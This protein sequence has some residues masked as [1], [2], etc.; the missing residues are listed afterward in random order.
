MILTHSYGVAFFSQVR[1]KRQGEF[2][3]R[4]RRYVLRAFLSVIAVGLAGQPAIA[5]I[6]A[7]APQSRQA[8]G[9]LTEQTWVRVGGPLG[10]LG[11]DIRMRPDNPDIMFVTDALA[12]VH[13]STD[14]GKTWFPSNDGIDGRQGL[15][16]DAIPAF[17][18]TIDPNNPDTV[19]AGLQNLGLVYR[20]TDGGKTWKRRL[21][22][23]VDGNGL[24]L[25]G[26]AVEPGNS[27]VVYTA[28]EISGWKWA[29][30]NTW[31]RQFER[32]KGVVYKSTDGGAN[33]RAVWRGDNL[34]RYV[35][36]DPKNVNTLYV[37]TGIFDREAANSDAAKQEPGGVGILKSTD[38]GKTWTQVNTGLRNLYTGS[39]FMN[40]ANPQILL[41]GAG[42]NTY[43]EGG[44]IYLTTDGG[45]HWKY[46][47]GE[48]ITSV[49]FA[50]SDPNIAYAGGD[51][52]FY[53]SQDGGQNWQLFMHRRGWGWG[54]DGVRAG[55]PI[56]FQVDPR[57]PAR[58]FVNNY[59]GGNFLSEDNGRTW[60]SSSTG[61]TGAELT[62]VS[63]HPSNPSIVYVNGRSGP[64]VSTN[65]GLTWRG[66]NLSAP[67]IAEGGRITLDPSNPDH[68]L[69]SSAHWGWTYEIAG[70]NG[71]ML[72]RT[73]LYD[74]LDRLPYPDVNQK[75]QG[76]QAIAFAPSKPNRVYG[77]F[78][79]WRCATGAEKPMCDTPTL[80][81]ILISDD[82]G[83][84]WNR[85]TGTALDGKTVTK[86]IVHPTNADMAWAA[87]GGAGVFRT[88]DGGSTWTALSNGLRSK[89]VTALAI[90]PTNPDVL[91]AATATSGVFKTKD[92]GATWRATGGGMD[93]NEP[94]W[95]VVVD[96]VYPEVVY[97][98]SPASGVF[99]SENGGTSWRRITKGLRTRAVKA[100]AI[101]SDGQT[102]YAATAGEGLFR[103][104]TLTQG[105][106]S[107]L[108]QP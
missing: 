98:G 21:N 25:R 67:P 105:Q 107:R 92:G 26:I 87:T 61:Y 37:S 8:P 108:S 99:V 86:I 38:G 60:V 95:A 81:S 9:A 35:L 79:V 23:I 80:V 68:V 28:G 65:G 90:D 33:W 47:G 29:G 75:F 89:L 49:E 42:N 97:A 62:D 44:G 36:I 82:G 55:F 19:W 41:T 94:I 102:L 51:N 3:C 66:L 63:V 77:G 88:V 57:N 96:P 40:P 1:P 100:L 93:P 69:L 59:G 12:G 24:S 83:R 76:M 73:N 34:A 103:L 104:S 13:K 11:Y 6:S 48:H 54:P 27:N 22:G 74:E 78:G 84:T 71:P 58:V 56:D 31:G 14:G 70:A 106:F 5:E 50:T 32:V 30:Q 16:G 17:C 18:L 20:S 7:P 43:G 91:Y 15:S 4:L 2:M 10:G 101:A 53:Y 72:L 85:R 39:L 52:E 46:V 45:E 64:F